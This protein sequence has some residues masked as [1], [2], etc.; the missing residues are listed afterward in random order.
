[1]KKSR[2]LAVLAGGIFCVALMSLYRML[3]LMQGAELQQGGSS[4]V[5]QGDKELSRLQQKIDRLEHLLKDNHRLVAT[6]KDALIHRNASWEKEGAGADISSVSSHSGADELPGCRSAGKMKDGA[7]GVQLLDV[8]DLLPFD[9]LDGGVWKQGFEIHYKGNEWDE[10]PLEIILVPHSHNDPGWLKT[11]DLYYQDQT[12]HI[13][14]NM[15]LKLS[16]DHRKKMI[17]AEVSYFSKW[18]NDIDDQKRE[19]VK[20]LVGAGQLELVTGGWVMADEANSH[21]FALLDQLIEGH[22]WIQRHLGVKPSSGWAIDPFGHSPSM[23]YLLKGAGL[24]NMVIQRVHYAVK[25]QFAQQQT[26]EFQW[27]QSWDSSPRS[28][29]TCHMMPFYSYDVPHTCGPNP[30]VCCQFDFHRLPGGRVF[31]PWRI[32]PQPI[33]EQN[34]QERALLLLDQYRQKSRLFRSPVLFI[35]LGDD[36]RFVE[37]SEWDAQFNNYQKLFDYF[38]QHPELHVKAQF[39][40]L[41]DYFQALERRLS[42]ADTKLPTLRGDFFTY[43]DRDDHYWSG[44]F[45][46]RPFY[47]RLDRMLEATLRATE[48]LFTL[49]LAEMRRFRGDSR[50][51]ADFPAQEHFQRLT[52]GRR[53]LALFQH[54]D[55]VTGTARDPVVVDYGIRLFHSIL[56]LRQVLQSSAHWLLLLDKSLY[57]HDQSKPF[58]LMDDVISAHDALPQKTPLVLSDEPRPLIIFNP[59]EQLK[60]SVITIVVDSLDA[61]VVDAETGQPLAAQISAVWTEPSRASTEAFQFSFVAELPPLSLVVYHVSKASVGSSH[62]AKYTIHRRGNTPTVHNKHFQVSHLTGPDA[63]KPVSLSNKHVQIWSS[64]ETGL[65]QKLR[66]QSGLVREVKIQFLWYGT[67]TRAHQEKS[68]A[69]LFLPGEEGAQLYSSS[70]PRLVR[71]SRGPIFSDITSCYQHFTHTVRLLHLDGHARKSLEISNTVDIRSEKNHELVMRLVSDVANGNRFFSDLNGFQMQQ[72]RTLAK[73]PLQANFYPMTSSSFLQDSG[74]RLTLLSAQSQAVAS[75]RPGELEVV[76]DRRLQQDDNRGLGQGV[77]DNK[78]TA[79]LFQLLLEERRGGTQDVG[80]ASVEHLSLLAHLSSLSL[81]HPPV[82]MVTHSIT[83]LPKLRPFQPLSSSLPCDIHLLNLRTLE[84]AQK[85]ESPS[86]EAALLLHRKGF[87]C[88]IIPNPAPVCTWSV[89]EEVNLADLFSPLQFRSVRHSGL[90]LLREDDHEEPPRPQQPPPQIT[91]LRP[92]EIT[93]YRVEID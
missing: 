74:S 88:S 23:A 63:D 2:V 79:S 18:W 13:L 87:D 24:S 59:T 57:Y 37:S 90:T 12:R 68:G 35:P 86:Q 15:L 47:K 8:Y 32:A 84:D 21:Y 50:V 48:I 81:C 39:G 25:K 5:V 42:S 54:H 67:R 14:N 28:D 26:L 64:L 69:Y 41:T 29:I 11:F 17:W 55:A 10:Q 20:R 6:L 45:T 77:T 75:L 16:E 30:S 76:L 60:T 78:L 9:N 27:R 65:L 82:T 1:M 61:R 71:I 73:L 44:Y 51:V 3:E 46:S 22:Q 58:L 62:R 33:T 38:D 83:K 92:M 49:T 93:A 19:M 53:S 89:H 34:I 70:K 56:S 72:R 7:D 43:A 40:T 52:A 31:C 66:L 4:P 36:F 80:G 85:A 91:R